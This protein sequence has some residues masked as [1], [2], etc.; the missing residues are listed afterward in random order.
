MI[1]EGQKHLS[2]SD[3]KAVE[4]LEGVLGIWGALYLREGMKIRGV[5]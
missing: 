1:Q 5:L 2:M 3:E 4:G